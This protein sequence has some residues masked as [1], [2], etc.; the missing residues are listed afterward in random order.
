MITQETLNKTGEQM[1][2]WLELLWFYF[3]FGCGVALLAVPTFLFF[4]LILN[5]IKGK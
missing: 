4:K 5:L 3:V 1:A 2:L